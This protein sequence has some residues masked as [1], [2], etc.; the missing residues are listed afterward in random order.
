M[1]VKG[2]LK[3]PN[4]P[5]LILYQKLG[6][7]NTNNQRDFSND[8][9]QTL[10]NSSTFYKDFQN[11][12]RGSQTGG[13]NHSQISEIIQQKG[14]KEEEKDLW[15]EFKSHFQK[16][17]RDK[18][19]INHHDFIDLPTISNPL[20]SKLNDS[21]F[22]WKANQQEQKD[23]TNNYLLDQERS[24]NHRKNLQQMKVRSIQLPL[25]SRFSSQRKRF[26]KSH[27]DVPLHQPKA[28]NNTVIEKQEERNKSVQPSKVQIRRQILQNQQDKAMKGLSKHFI[29][30]LIDGSSIFDQSSIAHLIDINERLALMIP[31]QIWQM[32]T[33]EKLN[34]Y[35]K[36]NLS[37]PAYILQKQN[38]KELIQEISEQ[39]GIQ[40]KILFTL[41]GQ[42]ITSL[43]QIPLQTK[44]L[45]AS[46][47]KQ[48][49]GIHGVE[50]L[51]TQL[52]I[53][54]NRQNLANK[55]KQIKREHSLDK[56]TTMH[57]WVQGACIEWVRKNDKFI[58]NSLLVQD[59]IDESEKNV[60]PL[61][62]DQEDDLGPKLRDLNK[63]KR[64][65]NIS[66]NN[67]KLGASKI[68]ETSPSNKLSFIMS[69]LYDLW[70]EIYINEFL[71]DEIVRLVYLKMETQKEQKQQ[72]IT[73]TIMEEFK[74]TGTKFQQQRLNSSVQFQ[75]SPFNSN[76]QST[77]TNRFFNRALNSTQASFNVNNQ[78]KLNISQ[79]S[80]I[81]KDNTQNMVTFKR[82]QQNETSLEQ[83]I[84][85]VMSSNKRPSKLQ[86]LGKT[87]KTAPISQNQNLI[88]N[89]DK[90]LKNDEIKDICDKH[91][92]SRKE[93]Y[94]IRSQFIS[95]SMLSKEDESRNDKD[96]QILGQ[97]TSQ[98]N[99]TSYKVKRQDQD[100]IQMNYFIKNCS[101]LSGTLPHICKRILVAI[102]KLNFYYH[103]LIY[104]YRT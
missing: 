1:H 57:S 91:R 92:L 8:Q 36:L 82:A 69:E 55:L 80:S 99:Q 40:L 3:N 58:N 86:S 71:E 102:G 51:E 74:Q 26:N 54:S 96:N 87:P 49:R 79:Y 44:I 29:Y 85:Q 77:L 6:H 53:K 67:V 42:R 19:E 39:Y 47:S 32:K 33:A 50:I 21:M 11:K 34:T 38:L 104:F 72:K 64:D 98:F 13:F 14:D 24:I 83:S 63:P 75:K 89:S 45:V 70:N 22:D 25:N 15:K 81:S 31:D 17:N 73:H 56:H 61:I 95:M 12:L 43:V 52:S 59:S 103:Q 90:M 60:S 94:D 37:A 27:F 88:K 68:S 23:F 100:G 7:P 16:K 9:Y 35:E 48:F 30:I 84:A 41:H 18:G 62:L 2:I 10:F 101:F 76:N 28:V 20:K 5:K 97:T 66:I 46:A 65:N 4:T 93:V 78:D